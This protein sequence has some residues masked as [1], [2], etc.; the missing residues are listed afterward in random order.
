MFALLQA[1]IHVS[2]MSK[3]RPGQ[4]P[5]S[6]PVC[7]VL[8]PSARRGSTQSASSHRLEERHHG[9]SQATEQ[10]TP[11]CAHATSTTLASD[12]SYPGFEVS[13]LFDSSSVLDTQAHVTLSFVQPLMQI[14]WKR[15]DNSRWSRRDPNRTI[16]VYS[17][18]I[19]VPNL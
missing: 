19:I 4:W 17:F 16:F 9:S 18:D 1:S 8:T 2:S 15:S 6:Q 14:I 13:R 12:S 10:P 7:Q 5:P 3:F 11:T